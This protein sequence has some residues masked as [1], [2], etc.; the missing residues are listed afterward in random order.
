[1]D[2]AGVR[3]EFLATFGKTAESKVEDYEPET[4]AT[5]LWCFATLKYS[6]GLSLLDAFVNRAI[7]RV[8]DFDQ[9]QMATTLWSIVVMGYSPAPELL[10][11]IEKNALQLLPSF[12]AE[13]LSGLLWAFG[14]LGHR[15]GAS[16]RCSQGEKRSLCSCGREDAP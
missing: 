10:Y 12:R 8:E 15:Y 14:E 5:T 1:F 3:A 9:R 6:P 11:R 13:H 7:S 16:S 4:L 2:L